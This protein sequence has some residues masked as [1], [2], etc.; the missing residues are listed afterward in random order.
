MEN[1]KI[2]ENVLLVDNVSEALY[3]C[4]EEGCE[5][6]SMLICEVVCSDGI[7]R[8]VHLVVTG[9]ENDFIDNSEEMPVFDHDDQYRLKDEIQ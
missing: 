4:I 1:S 9:H 5:S 3:E 7:K 8:Q 2:N 6:F